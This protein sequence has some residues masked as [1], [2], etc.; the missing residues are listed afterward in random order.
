[1]TTLIVVTSAFLF[2]E[3]ANVLALYFAPDSDK[4]NSVGV[5]KAWEKS[6]ED[7]DVH[8][9]VRYL[10]YWVAGTKLIF[11]LVLLAVLIYGDDRIR[12]IA[13]AGL[14]IAVLSY[15]WRLAPLA[16]KIDGRGLLNPDGY[17]TVLTVLITVFVIALGI[18]VAYGA[19]S[20]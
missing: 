18:G 9:L 19:A 7:S 16:R 17:S 15:Y 8:D 2:L 20:L 4:F 11:I 10:T 6:K 12:V 1:M 13:V 3:I 5:F 14:G